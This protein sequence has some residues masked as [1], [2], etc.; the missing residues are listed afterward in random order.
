[1]SSSDQTDCCTYPYI[2][3]NLLCAA[4]PEQAAVWCYPVA[5]REETDAETVV[6]NVVNSLLCRMHL[7]S[8]VDR[9][10]GD[11]LALLREGIAYWRS[12]APAR[13]SAHPVLPTGYAA[14][15]DRTV[16]S[17][18]VSGGRLY[19]AVWGL[20]AGGMSF[21]IPFGGGMRAR[22]VR[23]GYPV[24]LPTDFSWAPDALTVRFSAP[25][26]ARLFEVELE[27]T[28]K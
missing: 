14:F 11:L 26:Q 22:S 23:V 13:A 8:A 24:C 28:V 9:L 1:M 17:G 19:L 21:R 10:E 6:L 12:L 18:F 15:G 20:D 16:S 4:L 27:E 5:E 3:A 2:A 25:Y 7:A